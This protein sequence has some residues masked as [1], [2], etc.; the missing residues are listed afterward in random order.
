MN[1]LICSNNCKN[2]SDSFSNDDVKSDED[3]NGI[4]QM[5]MDYYN[6]IVMVHHGTIF[7]GNI[8]LRSVH[9]RELNGYDEQ[10]LAILGEK[11]FFPLLKQQN[12]LQELQLLWM[13]LKMISRLIQKVM[14]QS[15]LLI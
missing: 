15:Y 13:L 7:D 8:W 5:P 6:N 3:K 2:K 9:L 1:N 12:C 10:Y 11:K 14:K 4:K